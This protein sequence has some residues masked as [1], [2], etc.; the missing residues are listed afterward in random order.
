MSKSKLG[1]D[2]CDCGNRPSLTKTYYNKVVSVPENSHYHSIPDGEARSREVTL[3]KHLVIC[4]ACNRKTT[5]HGTKTRA[6]NAW[7]AGITEANADV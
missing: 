7:N 5:A 2:R 4:R 3:T 1:L 6:A